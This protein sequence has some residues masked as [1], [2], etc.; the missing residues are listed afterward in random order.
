MKRL[1]WLSPLWLL[2]LPLLAAVLLP[3]TDTGSRWALEHA[4]RFLE[5]ELEYQAGTL[6]GE[7]EVRRIAWTGDSVSIE[8][9]GV[10]LELS[11]RCL[12]YSRV[13]FEQLSAQEMKIALSSGSDS[14]AA[15]ETADDR[16]ETETDPGAL[17]GEKPQRQF[18][19]V[20]ALSRLCPS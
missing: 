3:F 1:L 18:G 12:W 15:V 16:A 20:E 4:G 7:L 19:I 9:S 11:P 2:L 14:E 17:V 13:C 10:V 5:L 8:L 6:A